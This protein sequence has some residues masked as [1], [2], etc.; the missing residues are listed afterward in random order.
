MLYR[1]R[2]VT[3]LDGYPIVKLQKKARRSIY[4]RNDGKM[5]GGLFMS[6]IMKKNKQSMSSYIIWVVTFGLLGLLLVPIVRYIAYVSKCHP[7]VCRWIFVT[8]F[9]I[10]FLYSVYLFLFKQEWNAG[11]LCI[12]MVMGINSILYNNNK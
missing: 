6:E 11:P 10:I 5:Q 4:V 3:L 8:V 9:S 7:K 12:C 2:C 1:F